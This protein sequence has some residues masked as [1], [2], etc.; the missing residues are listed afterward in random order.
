M[1]QGFYCAGQYALLP[2]DRPRTKIY[3]FSLIKKKIYT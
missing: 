1:E 2:E 3:S